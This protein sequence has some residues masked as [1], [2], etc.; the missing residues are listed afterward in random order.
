MMG[1]IITEIMLVNVEDEIDVRRGYISMDKVRKETVQATVDTGAMSLIITEELYEK[2]GLSQIDE[3]IAN[4]AN[5]MRL[6]SKVTSE[7]VIYCNKRRTVVNAV[8][9]PGAKR[10]LLGVLPLEGM[11]LIID[12]KKQTLVGVHGDEVVCTAY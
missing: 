3:I 10:I 12:P 4:L 11:D 1:Y 5:G 8:V 2:L 9:I 7:V 6:P